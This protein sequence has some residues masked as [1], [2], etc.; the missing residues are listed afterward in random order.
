MDEKKE[1]SIENKLT[2]Q[3]KRDQRSRRVNQARNNRGVRDGC[4]RQTSE[5]QD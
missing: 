2:T 5:Q 3:R 1:G 4:G